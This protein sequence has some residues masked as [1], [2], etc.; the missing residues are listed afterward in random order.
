[1][2][3]PTQSFESHRRYVPGYHYLLTAILFANLVY[4][5]VQA[6]RSPGGATAI[7]V[8]LAFGL[9]LLMWYVRAFA[10]GVQDRVIRLE[11]RLRYQ[12]C[13]PADLQARAEGLR[14]GQLV[15]LRFADDGELPGLVKQALD[16][17]LDGTAIKRQIKTW[18][19]DHMRV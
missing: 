3:N 6:V 1:M 17:N 7:G 19:A 10:V 12:R 4:A 14:K 8:A 18:R 2:S 15:A 11:E 9:M 16:N 5:M 13:L